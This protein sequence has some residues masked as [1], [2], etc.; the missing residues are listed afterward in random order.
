[1]GVRFF[2][3]AYILIGVGLI[4]YLLVYPACYLDSTTEGKIDSIWDLGENHDESHRYKYTY[5]FQMGGQA[6]SGTYVSEHIYHKDDTIMI[7][8]KEADPGWNTVYDLTS[9]IVGGVLSVCLVG[10]GVC[11]FITT[12]EL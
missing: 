11:S 9:M 8:Y 5:S 3:F 7:R 10:C 2:P 12:R 4:L 6:Y 1:M